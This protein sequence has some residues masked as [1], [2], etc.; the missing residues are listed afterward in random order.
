M[1]VPY[2]VNND[3]KYI[4]NLLQK[5]SVLEKVCENKI[6]S[7]YKSSSL[8]YLARYIIKKITN[9]KIVI[10]VVNACHLFH[11]EKDYLM[12]INII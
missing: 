8:V 9:I 4:Q 6:S 5:W 11:I 3:N 7:Y 12:K 2:S 1:N 10:I